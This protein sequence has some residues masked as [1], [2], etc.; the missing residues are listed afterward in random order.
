MSAADDP[1]EQPQSPISVSP[2]V[3][4]SGTRGSSVEES[5]GGSELEKGKQQELSP[6]E[7]LAALERKVDASPSASRSTIVSYHMLCTCLTLHR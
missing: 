7:E 1:A 2:A 6:N 5:E 4:E 3:E